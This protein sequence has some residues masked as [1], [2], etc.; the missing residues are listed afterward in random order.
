LIDSK[1]NYTYDANNK[2]E[3]RLTGLSPRAFNATLYYDSSKFGARV[4]VAHRS[5]YLNPGGAN[6]NENLFEFTNSSTRFDFS[7]KYKIIDQLEVSFEALNLTNTP[8]HT[9]V[10]TDANRLLRYA[11]TGRNFLLGARYTY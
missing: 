10:D 4:S 2:V 9:G 7:S 1:V 8:E 3:E 5:D 6:I 11:R